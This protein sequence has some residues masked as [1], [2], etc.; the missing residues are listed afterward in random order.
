M[1]YV[2]VAGLAQLLVALSDL[3]GLVCML[4]RKELNEQ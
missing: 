2:V 1:R 4:A 3:L